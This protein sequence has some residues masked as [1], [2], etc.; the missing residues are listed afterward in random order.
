MLD[1]TPDQLARTAAVQAAAHAVPAGQPV[2]NFLSTARIFERFIIT[3]IT[4][5]SKDDEGI[6]IGNTGILVRIEGK[7]ITPDLASRIRNAVEDA[8]ESAR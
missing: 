8:I 7:K 3:G 2:G 6:Q 4:R 5:V 1:L